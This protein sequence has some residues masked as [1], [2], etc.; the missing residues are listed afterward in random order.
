ME[1]V[2]RLRF[3][4]LHLIQPPV[5]LTL[6]YKWST[7]FASSHSITDCPLMLQ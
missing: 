1:R 3:L 6:K 7:A 5:V 2:N 4:P